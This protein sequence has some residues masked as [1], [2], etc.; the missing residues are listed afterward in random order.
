MVE[1]SKLT[2]ARAGTCFLRKSGVVSTDARCSTIKS[3]LLVELARDGG[4]G[5]GR[6]QPQRPLRPSP[7]TSA[8][9][10]RR[11]SKPRRRTR[12]RCRPYDGGT[13]SSPED[14]VHRGI[15]NLPARIEKTLR[16][17]LQR[18]LHVARTPARVTARELPGEPLPFDEATGGEFVDFPVG[19]RWGRPWG[20]TWLRI[21]A[22]AP[23]VLEGHR[24]ELVIDLGFDGGTPGFQSEGLAYDVE[25]RVI[26]GVEPRT[27]HLPFPDDVAPGATWTVFVEAASNPHLVSNPSPD[28]PDMGL[29]GDLATAPDR[30]LYEFRCAD[31]ALLDMEVFA[32]ML[33]VQVLDELRIELP[34][35]SPRRAQILQGLSDAIDELS[36]GP[37]APN[38]SAARAR[39]RPLLDA[40]A[41]ASAHRITGVGHA[42]IDSAWLWPVRE[43][44]RKCAR[45]FSNVLELI[46]DYPEFVFACSSAQQYAWVKEDQPELY[47]RIREAVTG[48]RFVPVGGM[49][50]EPD[51]NMPGP[52]GLV[53]QFTLGTRFFEEEFGIA[54]SEV[55]LPDSF[56]YSAA[57]P[58]IARLTEKRYL[59]SQKMSWSRTNRFPHTTFW[60]EGLDGSRVFTHFP[61]CNAYNT[62][63]TGA[64]LAKS[65]RQYAEHGRA[66]S[67][68]MPFGYGDGGGG[69]TREMVEIARRTA[70]LEGSPKVSLDAP[71]AF[72]VAAEEEYPQ[73][74]VWVGEM[75]LELHR[76]T[77][78]SQIAMKQGNRATEYLLTEA[79]HW[80]A[81]AAIEAG[82]TY[83]YDEFDALWQ[84]NSL[85]QF[86]DILPG[87]SIAWVHREA[88]EQ[89]AELARRARAITDGALA[90]LAG[91]GAGPVWLNPAPVPQ[92]GLLAFGSGVPAE[93]PPVT[94]TH[95]EDGTV[96]DNG[97]VVVRID[98]RGLVVSA[99]DVATGREALAGPANLL[100]LHPD[101]PTR[102]DAWDIEDYYRNRVED[103]TEHTA[104]GVRLD[105]PHAPSV[106]VSRRFGDSRAVQTMTLRAGERRLDC[107][108]WLDWQEPQHLLKVAFPT[109]VHTHSVLCET[110]FGHLERPVHRN[111]SW[112]AAKF[113][114]CAHRFVHVAEPGFGV[115][116]VNRA[117]YGHDVSRPESGD[118]RGP[119][120][121][122]VRLTL[123]RGPV[124][125]D[126]FTDRGEHT[127]HYG[128]AVGTDVADAVEE[129]WRMVM[130]PREVEGPLPPPLVTAGD[131]VSI[132][133]VKL[134]DDRSGDII[135]RCH[136][137]LGR[138]TTAALRFSRSVA[139]AEVVNLLERQDGESELL[140][141]LA[142]DGDVARAPLG[143]F[144]ILTLRVRLASDV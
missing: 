98:G 68:I 125:P 127:F 106:V 133:A 108:T 138:R 99:V 51:T 93:H 56:G 95:D 35:H 118:S 13:P 136:E 46:D 28:Q 144:Q 24:R 123:A 128:L 102:Y 104:I 43:T 117:T 101:L 74:P 90:A 27:T 30:L 131:G 39:L 134:A 2:S 130:P 8:G 40:P 120:P 7:R 47:A 55:W 69:P 79:E 19:T 91:D 80:A 129:G 34:E 124:H 4:A 36:P 100:Q 11:A 70:D 33:D 42:H 141:E 139:S 64:E 119:L 20:T 63:L 114:I 52:E 132:T 45:T 77:Y 9:W 44:R 66:N 121:T 25:G 78:T 113:E 67:S 82:V 58:Q 89:Y 135:V 86:H 12:G 109:T 87:T 31:A 84:E 76:G 116:I 48:G 107:E 6:N 92:R 96:L 143:P 105:D 142:I 115:S 122:T 37:V 60:W 54:G 16:E 41:E 73:A 5:D 81:Q 75:Y 140:T 3:H 1:G 59:L 15:A 103:L 85:L 65:A 14:S 18:S 83:P 38:A 62:A 29:L 61:P 53:R 17:R 112:D 88:R 26:K 111:T 50:V 21:E 137:A 57:L 72:F 22:V 49:W 71:E 94:V 10:F 97:I 32:L 110:Q 23:P 126:P